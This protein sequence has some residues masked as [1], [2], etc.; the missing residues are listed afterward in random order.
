MAM[1]FAPFYHLE[2]VS[3]HYD[4]CTSIWRPPLSKVPVLRNQVEHNSVSSLAFK[5]FNERA[6]AIMLTYIFVPLSLQRLVPVQTRLN[7]YRNRSSQESVAVALGD[8][9][10]H[11]PKVKEGREVKDRAGGSK[12]RGTLLTSAVSGCFKRNF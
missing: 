3:A 9:K 6:L 7:M 12:V 1:Y 11:A 2:C 4:A 10:K 8:S 5:H